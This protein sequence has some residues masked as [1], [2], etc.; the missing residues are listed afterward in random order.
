MVLTY[1]T[2]VSVIPCTDLSIGTWRRISSSATGYD[3]VAYVSEPK[4]CLTWFIHSAGYGF[5]MELPFHT[6]VDTE[7]KQVSSGAALAVLLLSQPP[8]FYMEKV[9]PNEEGFLS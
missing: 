4:R 1:T 3:L 8:L 9:A 7:F 5:K 6:I 2:A